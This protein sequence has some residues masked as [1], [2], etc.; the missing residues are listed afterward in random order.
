MIDLKYKSIVQLKDLMK[1]G[2][3]TPSEI[4]DFY[5]KNIEKFKH[6]NAVIEVFEDAKAQAKLWDEKYKNQDKL[7]CLAGIPI[8]IKDNIMYKGHICSC[9]SNFMKEYVAQYSSTAVQ[10]LLDNGAIILGRVNMDEFAMGGSCEKS[11]YGPTLNALNDK[12]V[13]GGSSGGSA[14]AVALDLCAAALGSDTGGSIRQPASFNGVV[15]FKG[16]YGRVSRYGLVAFAS[17]LDQIGPLTKTV[18]DS[19]LLMQV[20]SGKDDNDTTSA[21]CKV[22]DYFTDLNPQIQGKKFAVIDEVKQ[23]YSKTQY[24]NK[25]LKFLDW[26][27][28]NGAEIEE[29]SLK[30]YSLSLPVYYIIAPAE[31]TSNLGRFDGVKYTKCSSQAKNINEVYE[32][33]R[34]EGFGKEVKRRIML[35]NFVLSSGFYDAYYVKAKRIQ[36]LL[37][38]SLNE[39]LSR[40]D[41]IV[42]PTTFGEAFEIGAKQDPVSMYAEDM[43]TIIANLTGVPAISVPYEKGDNGLSLGIQILGKKFDE[44][45]VLNIAKFIET[46]KEEELCKSTK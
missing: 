28:K 44:Q 8:L 34:T 17:S 9:A 35:G 7:P 37:S 2:K 6:K 11:V 25:F 33:S 45:G 40:C 19:A 29:V 22:Q 39:I 43:F 36:Q 3:T 41:A 30:N 20:I 12:R 16:S 5:I 21:N 38:S 24:Y 1:Q 26:L 15:G 4:V 10:R 32:F 42:M 46:Y 13:A 23:L 18:E 31:A 27:K 14:V